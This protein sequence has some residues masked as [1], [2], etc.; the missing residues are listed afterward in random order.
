MRVIGCFM[1]IVSRLEWTYLETE[2][3]GREIYR[4]GR[5]KWLDETNRCVFCRN[6][7]LR[8][9]V[10]SFTGQD[11]SFSSM[12]FWVPNLSKRILGRAVNSDAHCR[13]ITRGFT[14]GNWYSA[15]RHG[16]YEFLWYLRAWISTMRLHALIDL[17]VDLVLHHFS[18][19]P[20]NNITIKN[21]ISWKLCT[22][23]FIL[24]D[25]G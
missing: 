9:T 15:C 6:I 23:L 2:S 8:E 11:N 5:L 7:S 10:A 21:R 17:V 14:R 1:S 16:R 22:F 3:I 13:R 18:C 12:C 4:T 24:D 20:A 19:Y 25:N